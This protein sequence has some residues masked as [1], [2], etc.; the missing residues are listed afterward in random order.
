MSG[1][2]PRHLLVSGSHGKKHSS[3]VMALS[4]FIHKG[5]FCEVLCYARM[6]LVAKRHNRNHTNALKTYKHLQT[7]PSCLIILVRFALVFA[8]YIVVYFVYARHCSMFV[9]ARHCRIFAYARHCRMFAPCPVDWQF[10][11]RSRCAAQSDLFAPQAFFALVLRTMAN[12]SNSFQ[13]SDD[14]LKELWRRQENQEFLNSK[15]VELYLVN[16]EDDPGTGRIV[17]GFWH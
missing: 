6:F 10:S 11:Q 16:H 5:V 2:R 14:A 3:N 1:F 12:E 8:L 13:L 9:Y 17:H 15:E 4:V 7:F